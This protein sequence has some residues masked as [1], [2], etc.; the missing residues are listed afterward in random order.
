[1]SKI[2][3][4]RIILFIITILLIMFLVGNYVFIEATKVDCFLKPDRSRNQISEFYTPPKDDGPFRGETW[5]KWVGYD[6]S[7]WWLKD[8][9]SE[10]III[11]NVN[12]EIKLDGLWIP[13]TYPNKKET[14]VILHGLKATY[15]EFN[16]LL[17]ASMLIKSDFNVLLIDFRNHGKSTCSTGRHEGGQKQVYDVSNTIDWLI[18]NKLIPKNKIGIHGISGGALSALLLP[19]V[20][21]RFAAM[22]VEG[23]PFD[24][25]MIANEEVSFQGFHSFLWRLAYWSAR[26]R[27]I[28]LDKIKTD[29]ALLNLKGKH[30][31]IFH[32]KQDSRVRYHHA[33][34]IRD[35]AIKNDISLSFFGFENSNHTEALLS[36]TENYR[37]KIT[38]FYIKHLR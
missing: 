2:F 7:K 18:N 30:L 21:N 4:I 25:N 11:N 26:L 14:I 36:E 17:T 38:K 23:A 34:K 27:G 35:F 5:Y 15:R 16:I 1:M 13:T 28:H 20:D 29:E 12:D 33:K 37:D 9:Y 8:Q 3:F 24:F 32:G 31:A 19:A 22:S 10:N 6:L